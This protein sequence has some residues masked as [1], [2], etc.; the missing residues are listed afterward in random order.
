MIL[1]ILAYL[2]IIVF[3]VAIL[4]KWLSPFTSLVLVPLVFTLVAILAGVSNEGNIGEF[5]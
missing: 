4:K 3:M 2:M 5:F 1:T